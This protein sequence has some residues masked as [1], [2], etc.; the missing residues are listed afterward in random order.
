MIR[1]GTISCRRLR[2]FAPQCFADSFVHSRSTCVPS[3]RSTSS[4]VAAIVAVATIVGCTTTDRTATS[5]QRLEFLTHAEFFTREG[6]RTLAVDP[7]VFVI[8]PSAP[9]ARG[10]QDIRHAEGL[11]NASPSDPL[12]TRLFNADGKPLDLTVGQWFFASGS[13]SLEPPVDGGQRL[14][15]TLRGLK[16]AGVYSLLDRRLDREPV[17]FASLDGSAAPGTFVVDA[18][19]GATITVVAPAGLTHDDAVV[20]I[21]H[22]DGIAPGVPGVDA[23]LQLAVRIP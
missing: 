12:A 17:G 11:R 8:Q 18:S 13:V 20:L 14:V 2:A 19:G 9:A 6:G 1:E 21:Y 10:P 16:P 22:A 7:Q 5:G 4:S 23:H 3:F 15:A